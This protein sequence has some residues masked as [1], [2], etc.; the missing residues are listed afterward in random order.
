VRSM[1][2]KENG[3]PYCRQLMQII[4]QQVARKE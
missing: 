1:I 3:I 2:D 4:Q